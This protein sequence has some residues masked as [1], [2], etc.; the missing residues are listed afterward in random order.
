MPYFMIG[1]GILIGLLFLL[2]VLTEPV[3]AVD[4]VPVSA[5]TTQPA[6]SAALA[7]LAV[8]GGAVLLAGIV[9][10]STLQRIP[11]KERPLAF[12][13]LHSAEK[14][15]HA[16]RNQQDKAQV[17]QEDKAVKDQSQDAKDL[18]D[19]FL[20]DADDAEYNAHQVCEETAAA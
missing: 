12:P 14:D 9:W 17:G 19:V 1:M 18:A 5:K 10:L 20:G 11:A 3:Q 4:A 2:A 8:V 13:C 7:C 6:E 16:K 15:H